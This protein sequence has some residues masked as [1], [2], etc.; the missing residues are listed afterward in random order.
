M[1]AAEKLEYEA[2]DQI[3][4]IS[5]PAKISVNY[6]EV[7]ARLE[8]EL[9]RY[10]VVVTAETLPGAKKLATELNKNAKEFDTR[11]KAAVE[12][13][14][15]PIRMFEDQMKSLVQ[16]CKDGRQKIL[17]QVQKFEDETRAAVLAE[18][19]VYM[20]QEWTEHG[21]KEEF[22]HATI[23]DLIKLTALTKTGKLTASVANEVKA[24]VQADK[25]LQQQTEMRLVQLEN[26][27][28]K[29]GLAAPL[30]RAHVE[31]FLFADDSQYQ[32]ALDNVMASELKREEVAQERM[33]QKIEQEER[34]KAEAIAAGERMKQAEAAREEIKPSVVA[35]PQQ[36]EPETQQPVLAP[37]PESATR[38]YAVGPLTEPARATIMECTWERVAQQASASYET[39]FGIWVPGELI[40]IGWQGQLIRKAA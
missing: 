30:T 11:R 18:L 6:E 32:I 38:K 25:A 22:Q 23:E 7:R 2:A 14:S 35:E 13:V 40:A 39:P 21:V 24:R 27:S 31:T 5:V 28:Y 34:R 37:P 1:S 33:R 17:D 10:D 26:Q 20:D 4:V 3:S 12:Q 36:P 8:Q 15:G 16:M 19:T 9:E 29:A